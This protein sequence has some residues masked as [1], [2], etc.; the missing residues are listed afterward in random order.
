MLASKEAEMSP[1]RTQ[2]VATTSSGSFHKYTVQG[3]KEA[4]RIQLAKVNIKDVQWK[5]RRTC[6]ILIPGIWSL[7]KTAYP[8]IT[9]TRSESSGSSMRNGTV[10]F[11]FSQLGQGLSMGLKS[12]RH[13]SSS[14]EKLQNFLS[15]SPNVMYIRILAIV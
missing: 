15:G 3:E 6:R 8:R 7:R 9:A 4:N 10:S 5:K 1:K 11:I 12:L 2:S 14:S 13:T